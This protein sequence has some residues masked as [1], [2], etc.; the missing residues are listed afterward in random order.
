MT[1]ELAES[2]GV[3]T[4]TSVSRDGQGTGQ[5]VVAEFDTA[6]ARMLGD[7]SGA[8]VEKQLAVLLGGQV[9][10]A[11]VVKEPITAGR[12]AFAFGTAA[13]AAQVAA[14]LGASATS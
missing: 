5:T 3:V 8:A 14:E 1:Y 12:A 6:D 9:L 10:S 11:P 13:E 4:P 2:L 7:V